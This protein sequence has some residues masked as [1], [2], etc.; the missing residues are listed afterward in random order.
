M[1][2]RHYLSPWHNDITCHHNT[3]T[4]LATMTKRQ[5]LSP[6]HNDSTCHHDTAIVI[7][8][9]TKRQCLSP[10]Q[11][12]SDCHHDT[13]TVLVTMTQRQ[14]LSPWHNDSDC[15]HDTTTVRSVGY[16]KNC[17]LVGPRRVRVSGIRKIEMFRHVF[18]MFWNPSVSFF[19]TSGNLLGTSKILRHP[20]FKSC[21]YRLSVEW[22]IKKPIV[23]TST[24]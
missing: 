23:Y 1:T 22:Y 15:H 24:S 11:N 7:A 6:W 3:T 18:E 8:T 21:W 2:Q 14:W 5:C 13:T 16:H 12:D 10:W 4:V 17:R 20:H 19:K 9:M